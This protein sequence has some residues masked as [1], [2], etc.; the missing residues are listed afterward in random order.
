MINEKTILF[1][2]QNT[3][4]ISNNTHR[5]NINTLTDHQSLRALALQIDLR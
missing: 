2:M 4:D 3:P 1:K 5:W